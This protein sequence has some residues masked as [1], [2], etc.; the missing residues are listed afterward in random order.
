MF[1]RSTKS[2]PFIHIYKTVDMG[3]F[4][5]FFLIVT[6]ISIIFSGMDMKVFH[7]NV[8]NINGPTRLFDGRSCMEWLNNKFLPSLLLLLSTSIQ[9]AWGLHLIIISLST[10]A[11]HFKLAHALITVNHYGTPGLLRILH[12]EKM[13]SS[14][15]L[16]MF[17]SS[18]E[19]EGWIWPQVWHVP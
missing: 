2:L 6:L 17:A 7:G 12:N 14:G 10:P 16:N 5:L 8:I 11:V 3:F 19:A 15:H 4:F 9:N 13:L 1:I 18:H